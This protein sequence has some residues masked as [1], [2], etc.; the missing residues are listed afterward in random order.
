MEKHKI[1]IE[2]SAIYLSLGNPDANVKNVLFVC[3]GYA[4]S[5]NEF[6]EN[7]IAVQNKENYI[8]APEGLHRFYLRGSTEKVVASWMTKEEREDDIR[9][10]V[11]FL[12]KV[13][14]KVM[15]QFSSVVKVTVVGFSQGAAT[16]CRWAVMGNSKID[17]LVLWCGYFPPDLEATKIPSH[18]GVTV[19][20]ASN[21]KWISGDQEKEIVGQIKK[22]SPQ[23]NHVRFEGQHEIDIVT[24]KKVI[25]D[26]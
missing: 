12:D 7:F 6:L 17:K 14:H 23:M 11:L 5:A 2:K 13:Y 20:T 15:Q 3:H 21:D 19:V 25:S 22:L 24:L 18:I 8:V 10:Y 16:V 4:Q 9:D 1:Q 26:L